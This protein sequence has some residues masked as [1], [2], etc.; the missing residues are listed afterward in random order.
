MQF[1]SKASTFAHSVIKAA[2]T[3]RLP[4]STTVRLTYGIGGNADKVP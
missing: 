1:C 2:I 4:S 3:A